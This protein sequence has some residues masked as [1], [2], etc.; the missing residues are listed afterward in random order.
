MTS[1]STRRAVGYTAF[2]LAWSLALLEPLARAA[3]PASPSE[4]GRIAYL[5]PA[6]PYWQVWLMNPDGSA[7]KQLT[8]SPY[9]KAHLSWF[10][11]GK[12]LLVNA[13][14]G[15]LYRVDAETGAEQPIALALPNR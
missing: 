3:T 11:D 1:T 14:D 6:G 2:L 9:E 10:P 13:L 7:A 5:S 4:S 12:S 15:H 8:R